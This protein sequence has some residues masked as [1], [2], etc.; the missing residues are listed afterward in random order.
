[1]KQRIFVNLPVRDLDRSKEFFARLGF[2]FDP[3][4]TDDD[5]ACMVVSDTIFVML[6]T[7]EKFREFTPN[8]VC[9]ASESTEAIVCLTCESR[10]AVDEMVRKAVAAGGK[11]YKNHLDQGFMYGHGFQDLDGHIWE[12]M[13]MAPAAL[14]ESKPELS[15]PAKPM[16]RY[17]DGFVLPVPKKNLDLYLAMAESAAKVWREHGAL[18]YRECVG[19]DLSVEGMMPFP[20]VVALKPDET[21]VFAWITY[22]SREH[23]DAVNA[24]V[25]KDPRIAGLDPA[26]MPF[27]CKRMVY[28]GFKTIVEA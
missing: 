16:K 2:G 27:D 6:L 3:R 19:D 20:G 23:R 22:E 15:A 13:W 24:K 26:A 4:F 17:V 14:E 5:G 18:E 28:G 8:P 25:M 1:M 12:L 10:E 9:D 11:T 21:V 7:H